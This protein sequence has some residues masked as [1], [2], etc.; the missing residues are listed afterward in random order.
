MHSMLPSAVPG[1]PGTLEAPPAAAPLL[2]A[3]ALAAELPGLAVLEAPEAPVPA[4]PL[5][6]LA[7]VPPLPAAAAE[8][9]ELVLAPVDPA[10]GVEPL[11]L[12]AAELVDEPEFPEAAV[13]SVPVAMS[14]SAPP[15]QAASSAR[16]ESEPKLTDLMLGPHANQALSMHV[17]IERF[18]P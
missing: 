3:A 4:F 12:P 11:P 8:P 10:F 18:G 15:P 14:L 13:L 9:L 16:S 5:E 7:L 17:L 6:A 2:P 1:T